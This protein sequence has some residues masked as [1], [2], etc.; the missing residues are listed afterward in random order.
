MS[1]T[2]STLK[3]DQALQH[4]RA[5]ARLT[6]MHGEPGHCWFIVPGG[7]V[8]DAVASKIRDHPAVV[9]GSDG[10]FPH[11]DQTWRMLSFVAASSVPPEGT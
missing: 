6:R 1:K 2:A 3:L 11:H 9:A 5:G 8:T 10:L 7:A 4:M